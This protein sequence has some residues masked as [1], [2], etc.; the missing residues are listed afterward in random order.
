M[1]IPWAIYPR[2]AVRLLTDKAYF[3]GP[4]W[5]VILIILSNDGLAR[6]ALEFTY[7]STWYRENNDRM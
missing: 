6:A 5:G 4:Q 2:S 7:S 1:H 3:Y